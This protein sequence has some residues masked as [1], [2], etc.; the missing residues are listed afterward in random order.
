MQPTPAVRRRAPRQPVRRAP[1]LAALLTLAALAALA[2]A[3]GGGPDAGLERVVYAGSKWYGHAPVWA[4]VEQGI[5]ERHG[6]RVE[7]LTFGTSADRVTALETDRAQLSSLGEV[8]MLA[9]M[10]AERRGFYWVGNQDI[11]PGNEGLVAV[12]VDTVAELRGKKIAVLL[13]TSVHV[14]VA[15]LLEE[16]GLDPLRD[17]ELVHAQDASAVPSLVRNG[18]VAAGCIWEPHYSQLLAV[19][20]AKLLGTD[21]DTDLY[22]RFRTMTGPDVVC[23]SRRWVDADEARARRL[24]TAYF[25]AVRWCKDNPEELRALV[26]RE[27]GQSAQEVAAALDRMVWLDGADQRVVMSNAR[28]FGQAEALSEVLVRLG[29]IGSAPPFRDWTRLDL[30]PE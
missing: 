23:A 12:G 7:Q 18:T 3:C 28:M 30:L 20:G 15:M 2:G 22:R 24:V 17:V 9:A 16:H 4:G 25:E 29:V 19:P 10:A 21:E 5:F 6:F 13:N 11:A 14:T 1:A 8:A 27:T 26:A